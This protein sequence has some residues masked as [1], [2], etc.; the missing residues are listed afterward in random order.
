MI[1]HLVYVFTL[2]ALLAIVIPLI[3]SLKKWHLPVIRSSF[4]IL[5][6]F[7]LAAL[8]FFLGANAPCT[9]AFCNLGIAALFSII[10]F[11][12]GIIL[13]I[14]LLKTIKIKESTA[15]YRTLLILNLLIN[16]GIITLAYFIL[17]EQHVSLF[18]ALFYWYIPSY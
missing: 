18:P 1:F 15:R 4:S 6:G 16:L 5:F 9:G 13:S 14:S 7:G 3:P 17:L 11:I 10:G 8:G 2:Y 12:L